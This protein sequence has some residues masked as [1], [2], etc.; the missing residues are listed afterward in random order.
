MNSSIFDP[1]R[2]DEDLTPELRAIYRNVVEELQHRGLPVSEKKLMVIGETE[3][4]AFISIS[5]FLG[6][7][8]E[9]STDNPVRLAAERMITESRD[10]PDELFLFLRCFETCDVSMTVLH[11]IRMT[12]GGDA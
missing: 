5:D 10:R 3:G 12:N 8:G 6:W 4:F 2:A 1:D 7:L 11:C 9:E